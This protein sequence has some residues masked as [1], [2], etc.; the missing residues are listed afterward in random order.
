ME[1]KWVPCKT[2][3]CCPTSTLAPHSFSYSFSGVDD[4]KNK[5]C[6]NGGTCKDGHNKYTC[7]CKKNYFGTNC[8]SKYLIQKIQTR[9]IITLTHFYLETHKRVIGKQC[10]PRSDAT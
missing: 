8:E 10:R 2:R 3:L 1:D 6:K 7:S 9:K 5:P 4:C